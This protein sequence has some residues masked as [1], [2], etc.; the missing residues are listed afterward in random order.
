MVTDSI[1]IKNWGYC[2]D[3][4]KY[5]QKIIDAFCNIAGF[6]RV[7]TRTKNHESYLVVSGCYCHLSCSFID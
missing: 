7:Y 4:I 2:L 5:N 6:L 1:L 3:S